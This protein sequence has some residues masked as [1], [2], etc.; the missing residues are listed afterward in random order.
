MDKLAAIKMAEVQGVLAALVDAELVKVASEDAFH[1]LTEVVCENLDKDY[2]LNE[3]LSKTAAIIEAVN[4]EAAEPMEKE[5]EELDEV[6]QALL[7][8]HELV[9][10]KQAGEV[11][12]DEF[13]KEASKIRNALSSTKKGY[14]D[15]M[16]APFKKNKKGNNKMVGQLKHLLQK[17]N[18]RNAIDNP[19]GN[20]GVA[21]RSVGRSAAAY[22]GTGTVAAGAAVGGKKALDKD[23]D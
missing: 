5:A 1:T 11:S 9:L 3:V 2:D 19:K 8:H 4:A 10:M 15:A 7:A 20:A 21:L 14:T 18:V 17:G 22:G 12:D 6:G 16:A 23:K 13:M